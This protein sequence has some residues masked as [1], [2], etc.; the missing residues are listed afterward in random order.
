MSNAKH[1]IHRP[2]L[3]N[4]VIS[5]LN[6]RPGKKYIDATLGLGG[7]SI[8]LVRNGGNVL[9][10]DTDPETLSIARERLTAQCQIIQG[11][12]IGTNQTGDTWISAYGNEKGILMGSWAHQVLKVSA[13]LQ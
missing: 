2:V 12:F 3:L 6:V 9:G 4:E 10:I 11:N 7:H 1:Q 13:T 8:A 5:Y